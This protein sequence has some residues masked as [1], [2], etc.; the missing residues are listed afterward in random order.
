MCCSCGCKGK[1]GFGTDPVNFRNCLGGLRL[2][3]V[4][5]NN[6]QISSL[7]HVLQVF[8][9][10]LFLSLSHRPLLPSLVH[11]VL[12]C[13]SNVEQLLFFFLGSCDVC[14]QAALSSPCCRMC[15]HLMHLARLGHCA[16]WPAASCFSRRPESL[17]HAP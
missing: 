16:L 14:V 13:L 10:V 2:Q 5:D 4:S 15:A 8:S 1:G 17:G 11:Q 6:L 12:A 3:P 9:P 7:N